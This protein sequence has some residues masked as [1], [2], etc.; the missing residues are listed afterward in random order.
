M[1][2]LGTFLALT[3][4]ALLLLGQGAPNNGSYMTP[5]GAGS[6][7]GGGVT[8]HGS[9]TSGDCASWFASGSIQ[10]AGAPCG[11]GGN[12]IT[13]TAGT[14]IAAGTSVS[15]NTSGQA[16]QTWGPAPNIPG[17]VTV[18]P[19]YNQV[20]ASVLALSS[21]QFVGWTSSENVTK[22]VEITKSGTSLTVGTVETEA[23][24]LAKLIPLTSTTFVYFDAAG[25]SY[26]GTVSGSATSLG[27]PTALGASILEAQPL[28]S[29]QFVAALSNGTAIVCGISVT[30]ITCGDAAAIGSG[31]FNSI[32][33]IEPLSATAF[34]VVY[35]DGANSNQLTGVAA[36][37]SGTTIT[38]GS[39]A[40]FNA[41]PFMLSNAGVL[42]TTSFVV[43]Y[44]PT[45]ANPIQ[46]DYAVVGS[47]SGTTLTFGTQ[48]ILTNSGTEPPTMGAVTPPVLNVVSQIPVLVVSS[49]QVIFGTGLVLPQI[50]TV[51]GTNLTVPTAIPLT[52]LAVNATAPPITAILTGGIYSGS[53]AINS[54]VSVGSNFMVVDAMSNVYEIIGSVASPIIQHLNLYNY[55]LTPADGTTVVG[56][57]LDFNNNFMA[58]VITYEPINNGPIGFAA[59]ACANGN[60][61]TITIYGIATGFSGLSPGVTYYSNGDGT[62]TLG[63]TGGVGTLAGVA[64][65]SSTFLIQRGRTNYLLKRDLDPASNDNSPAFMDQAA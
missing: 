52:N 28:S 11:G 53:L 20:Y 58:R 4:V 46:A 12:T 36:T 55:G 63:N 19:G 37:V 1:K 65:T 8:Q 32:A 47:V 3:A 34:A 48:A 50:V 2:R 35:S 56:W 59:T 10:D 21:T 5:N 60:P 27:S 33:Q 43:A 44:T 26:V 64:L 62:L 15:I 13:L 18:I 6:S 7:G 23:L 30:T 45:G 39:A 31:N 61:C 25:N 17:V 29:S 54:I 41:T 57:F 14:N 49:T 16:V 38:A 42:S 9:V 40:T 24:S 22:L 51:S